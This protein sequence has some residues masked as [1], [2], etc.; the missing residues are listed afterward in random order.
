[1]TYL[2]ALLVSFTA[3]A[4]VKDAFEKTYPR[5]NSFC[6]VGGK[7]IEI[8]IRGFQS[9]TEPRER[10]W[11]EKVFLKTT[12]GKLIALPVTS[13]DGLYR[14][15]PGNPSSCTKVVGTSVGGRFA[16]LFQ[17]LNRPHKNRLVIQYLDPVT[18]TP[19]ET[20]YSPYLSDKAQVTRN[21]FS[22]RTFPQ[23]RQEIEMGKI[24]I[25]GKKY[26]Y[27]DHVFPTWVQMDSSGFSPEPEAT[28]Q[29][30]TYKNF[31]KNVDDFKNQT[32][33]NDTDKSF[34]RTKLYVAINHAS[35]SKCILLLDSKRP[36]TENESW[37]CQ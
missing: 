33:W 4:D 30:F 27:Q 21:G 19:V 9:H 20:V 18:Q 10:M 12:E 11:G 15:F 17:K 37:I 13:E 24:M 36:L 16:V 8:L 32:G 14:F 29:N 3:S 1:M 31:F 2:I 22:L 23:A 5:D 35:K 26:L 34:M 6:Q 25:H 28:F 7:K